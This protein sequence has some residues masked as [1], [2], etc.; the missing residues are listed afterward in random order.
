MTAPSVVVISRDQDVTADLVVAELTRR[1]VGVARF[2]LAAFPQ[3]LTQVA[4][5]VSGRTQWTGV[6]RGE[7]RDVD[8]HKVRAIWYR[9]PSTFQFHPGMSA[10]EQRWSAAEAREGFGGLLAALPQVHWVNHPARNAMASKPR[11]LQVA[12]EAGLLVPDTVITNDPVQARDFCCAHHAEGVIYKPLCGGPSSEDGHRVVLWATPVTAEGITDAVRHTVHL[13]QARVPCAYAARLTVV[14]DRMF[15]ARLDTPPGGEVVDWRA[16]DDLT[17]TPV[18]TPA[19]VAAGMRHLMGVFGLVYATADFVVDHDGR[20]HF[21]GDLNPNGQWAWITPWRDA[22]C[23][24]LAD[25][26][27]RTNS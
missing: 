5:L 4:Y 3:R 16:V 13:F 11:Q 23:T 22:I 25:E 2:D 19:D 17:L 20:W 7:Y 8:L 6:L 12:T 21:I 1:G 18:E 24:A 15:A 9:K 10:T 27:T 14:G 26:L